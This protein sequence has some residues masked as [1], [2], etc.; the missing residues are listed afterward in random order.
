MSLNKDKTLLIYTLNLLIFYWCDE[1]SK[2]QIMHSL[3]HIVS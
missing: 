1:Y 2:T 3:Y